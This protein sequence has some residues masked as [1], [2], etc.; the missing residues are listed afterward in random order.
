MTKFLYLA[1]FFVIATVSSAFAVQ[2]GYPIYYNSYTKNPQC[3]SYEDGKC[4][5]PMQNNYM[6]GGQYSQTQ[7]G[8]YSQQ[9]SQ[10]YSSSQRTETKK[11]KRV[12]KQ[13][14]YEKFTKN[15]GEKEIELG[16]WA[17]R[18]FA[19]FEYQL[20]FGYSYNSG[21]YTH[22]GPAVSKPAGSILEWD[23]M[24]FN[25]L[26]ITARKDFKYKKY[27]LFVFGEYKQGKLEK[28]GDSRDDDLTVDDLWDISIGGIEATTSGWKF[29][30]GWNN[31]F[32]WSDFTFSPVFGYMS[33]TH[34]LNMTNQ[35]YAQP[36]Q[37]VYMY[38]PDLNGDGTP[39][40]IYE[41]DG[42]THMCLWNSDLANVLPNIDISLD[43]GTLIFDF[44]ENFWDEGDSDGNGDQTSW[45]GCDISNQY[46]NTN[47]SGND[48][49][50]YEDFLQFDIEPDAN[51]PSAGCMLGGYDVS[52]ALGGQTQKY[53]AT[54][55]GFFIGTY[56]DRQFNPRESLSFY[57]QVAMLDYTATAD[58]VYRTDLAHPSFEDNAS[59]MG[60]EL[61]MTYTRE[62]VPTWDFQLSVDWENFEL[63]GGTTTIH[64]AEA[65]DDH[66]L[67]SSEPFANYA[68]WQSMGLR[69]G[70]IKKF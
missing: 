15:K 10:N 64:W 55:S 35:I 28:S 23:D 56:M 38:G 49:L 44:D 1:M 5:A 27:P 53:E 68:V 46:C 61:R 45:I 66:G 65:T 51:D 30:I 41:D 57:A 13:A 18:R 12:S 67:T 14:G 24:I 22:Q 9:R 20:N 33:Q 7:G 21:N 69:I 47:D 37:T 63:S 70:V 17:G 32:Q 6:Q 34:D 40:P 31:A 62:I 4:I 39:D 52:V 43:D 50:T 42:E 8:Q 36:D 26:G 11:T 54:W 59:G 25:E 2:E 60:Y 29:G 48:P 16:I 58:W 3:N 19:D